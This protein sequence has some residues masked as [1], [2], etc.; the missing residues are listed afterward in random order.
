VET[1][2]RHL[3]LEFFGCDPRVLNDIE[4]VRSILREAAE[5]GSARVVAEVFHPFSPHGVTGVVVIEESHLS[6]HTWP[7]SGYAAVDFY[8][9]GDARLHHATLRLA[10]GLDAERVECLEVR[11]G[12]PPEQTLACGERKTLRRP[13]VLPPS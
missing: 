8:T 5:A 12:M 13:Y 7:E 6:I 1:L 9:C 2:A 4:R 3:L 11:R 10:Q